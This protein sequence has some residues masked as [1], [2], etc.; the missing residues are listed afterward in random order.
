L[1]HLGEVAKLQEAFV[2][3]RSTVS[4]SKGTNWGEVGA[5]FGPSNAQQNQRDIQMFLI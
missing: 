4:T 1:D 5:G 3:P 2:V